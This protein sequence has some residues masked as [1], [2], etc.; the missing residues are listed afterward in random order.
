MNLQAEF[1]VPIARLAF[2]LSLPP[3]LFLFLPPVT[4]SD[5]NGLSSMF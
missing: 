1:G 3:T 4:H 2:S 5:L